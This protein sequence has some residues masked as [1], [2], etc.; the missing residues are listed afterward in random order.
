[1]LN[2]NISPL[3]A[4]LARGLLGAALLGG[5]VVLAFVGQSEATSPAEP[6]SSRPVRVAR[7]HTRALA[8]SPH[9]WATLRHEDR[10]ALGFTIAGRIATVRVE[11]GSHVRR[12]DVL[13][14][15]DGRGYRHGARGAEAD[16]AQREAELEQ[17]DRDRERADALV[18]AGVASAE[19]GER[20]STGTTRARAGIDAASA[21]LAESRRLIGEATLRAPFDGVVVSVAAQEGEIAAPGVP[22]V[23][24]V[25]DGALEIVADLPEAYTR[26]LAPG[27][28]V[29]VRDGAR[30]PYTARVTG[31]ASEAGPRQ[32]IRVVLG[33]D[34]PRDLLG[35]RTVE[36]VLPAPGR[37]A[38]VAPLAAVL[39]P[40]GTAPFA[41][42]V[43]GGVAERSAVELG[44]VI[45][46]EVEIRSGLRDGDL[47]VVGGRALLLDREAV[48]IL[49]PEAL[50]RAGAE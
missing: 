21:Q 4:T 38:V 47:V 16:L 29:E 35:G 22:M 8:E 42:R 15:L 24:L 1:M 33:V 13:V 11:V 3:A 43:R 50:A 44:E 40:S 7:V 39:D 45:G 41:Y 37:S 14:A 46:D 49:A 48:E 26:G 20:A 30:A 2:K 17:L 6:A 27:T 34:D 23:E 10:A 18:R 25:G 12:G 28:A 36:L 19:D 32:L 31:I 9:V 5:A